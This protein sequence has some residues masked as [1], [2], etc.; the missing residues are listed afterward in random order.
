MQR[1]KT[2]QFVI[3]A[4]LTGL[5]MLIGCAQPDPAETLKP[6]TDA[7]VEVWNT[8]NYEVLDRICDPNFELRVTPGYEVAV[9]LDSLKAEMTR[10]RTMFPDFHVTI[11]ERFY[12]TNAVFSRW[13]V[14]GTH[15]GPGLIPPTGKKVTTR[16]MSLLYIEGGKLKGGWIAKDNLGWMKQLGFTVVPPADTEE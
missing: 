5:L 3:L 9:G 15:M 6:L 2:N 8:G 4:A 16:G 13:T 11:D 14:T 7:F 10:N 1:F 12:T